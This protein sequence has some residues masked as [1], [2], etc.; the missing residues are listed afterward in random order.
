MFVSYCID[1]IW[2]GKEIFKINTVLFKKIFKNVS[3]IHCDDQVHNQKRIQDLVKQLRY[4][5]M[6]K[7]LTAK[8]R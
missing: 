7:Q 6:R 4:Y 3:L 1:L 8:S 2:P 5:F